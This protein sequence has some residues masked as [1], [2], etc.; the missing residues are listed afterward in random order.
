[1]RVDGTLPDEVPR[2]V[3]LAERGQR[4][5]DRAAGHRGT[6]ADAALRADPEVV[7]AE[8]RNGAVAP[9]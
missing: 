2:R 5:E 8:T 7:R 4:D 9:G 3:V 1:M 6:P